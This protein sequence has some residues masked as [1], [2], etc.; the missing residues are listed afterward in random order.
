MVIAIIAILASMILPALSKAKAKAQRTT[1]INNQ[2]Q[3]SLAMKMYADDNGDWLAFPNWGNTYVGWLY[4]PSGGNPPI[5][6]E[7]ANL[8]NLISVYEKGQWYK[9]MPNP[10]AYLCPTDITRP[11]YQKLTSKGGRPNKLSSYVQDG[12]VCG[13]DNVPAANGGGRTTKLT[14]AWSGMCYLLWEPD[15]TALKD[16][17]TPIDWFEFNDASNF[18]APPEGIGKLHGGKGGTIL[19][20]AGHV[21]FLTFNQFQNDSTTP[22]GQ[23][24]GPG[25]KT[26]LWWSVY[27]G[28]GH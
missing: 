10:K 15:D 23:G 8:L 12:A 1:C 26:Y 25:G 22:S 27:R 2:K 14:S 5:I 9:Y 18:P 24:P 6:D 17:G 19:A 7:G 21:Q 20:L 11:S 13:F 28:D 3:M 4:A 16:D